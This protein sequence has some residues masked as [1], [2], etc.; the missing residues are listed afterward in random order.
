VA[1]QG[2]KDTI[3]KV[4]NVKEPEVVNTLHDLLPH[5]KWL[6]TVENDLKLVKPKVDAQLDEQG[7]I[8]ENLRN[9]SKG[10]VQNAKQ[11]IHTYLD[12]LVAKSK[13][14]GLDKDAVTQGIHTVRD[15]VTSKLTDDE[16]SLKDL[17][18]LKRKV[19]SQISTWKR[20]APVTDTVKKAE[21][22]TLR[23]VRARIQDLENK[24]EPAAETVNAKIHNLIQTSEALEKK[25]PTL[26]TAEKAAAS[27]ASGIRKNVTDVAKGI[28]K[29]ALVYGSGLGLGYLGLEGVKHII[30]E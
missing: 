20:Q 3:S 12:D 14:F 11:N 2:L 10:T 17:N 26:D 5:E 23:G 13:D 30:G 7:N 9:T 28:G 22:E 27:Y 1:T 29:R 15:E 21:Q 8:L 24:A 4:A 18:D 19:D 25:F 6:S 16:M